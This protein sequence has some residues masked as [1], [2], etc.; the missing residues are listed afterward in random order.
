MFPFN[1]ILDE[2]EFMSALPANDLD[3]VNLNSMSK[4]LF[5]PFE[6]NEDPSYIPGFEYDPDIHFFN[7]ISQNIN[8]NSNCYLED[9]FKSCVS[10]MS[11]NNSIFSLFHMNIRSTK[12]NLNKMLAYLE[13]LSHKFD[14]IG[15]S[16]TWLKEIEADLYD[17]PGNNHVVLPRVYAERGG[18]LLY[19][20]NIFSY[21]VRKYLS[22]RNEYCECLFIEI[23]DVEPVLIAIVYR[24]PGTDLETFTE[25]ISNKLDIVKSD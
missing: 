24:R 8:F 7:Q 9:G 19:V 25:F 16:E 4:L 20:K 14:I 21:E 5:V 2:T 22:F 18:V 15:L 3:Y 11:T 13:T 1:H 12:N 10:E 17:I 23:A 6:F